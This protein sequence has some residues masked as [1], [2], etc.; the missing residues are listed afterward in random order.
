[1]WAWLHSLLFPNEAAS[2]VQPLDEEA[3][4]QA[5]KESTQAAERVERLVRDRTLRLQQLEERLRLYERSTSGEDSR[6][7]E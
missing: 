2:R 3:L 4:A 7:G 1:M 6:V 5:A